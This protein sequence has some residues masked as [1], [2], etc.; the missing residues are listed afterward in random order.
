MKRGAHVECPH[1]NGAG[2]GFSPRRLRFELGS[3]LCECSCHASCPVQYEAHRR[4]IS[5]KAW[6]TSCTCTGAKA[7]RQRLDDA[8]IKVRDFAEFHEERQRRHNAGREAIEATRARARGRSR[9]EIKEI[10]LAER[11]ARNLE[12]PAEPVLDA[13]VEHI[14]TGSQLPLIRALLQM[15]KR[16]YDDASRPR[17]RHAKARTEQPTE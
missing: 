16:T 12:V 1:L 10:Y 17:G 4:T 3:H 9:E 15:G 2:G 8:G 11:R 14:T 13:V 5:E 6:Y 7:T